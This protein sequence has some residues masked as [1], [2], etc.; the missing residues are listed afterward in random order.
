[1]TEE[2]Q[3]KKEKFSRLKSFLTCPLFSKKK[4]D[5]LREVHSESEKINDRIQT[6]ESSLKQFGKL[7]EESV[8]DLR[9]QQKAHSKKME[10]D[11]DRL[12]S[13]IESHI[14]KLCSALAGQTAQVQQFQK[15][16]LNKVDD[17][18]G[19]I[20]G[21]NGSIGGIRDY[22]SENNKTLQ[23]FQAGYDYQILKNFVK[24][25]T[26]TI[27]DLNQL[28]VKLSGDEKEDLMDA[29]DD[30][31]E[32]LERNG[33]EQ[34]EL[35][36]DAPYADQKKYAEAGEEKEKADDPQKSGLIASVERM[37]Y[38]YEFNDGQERVI[39]VARVKLYE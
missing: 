15:M 34:I 39:Q 17:A 32:L 6:V 12:N 35:D 23:R 8:K 21:V 38:R 18:A 7:L 22:L 10:R 36:F 33:V 2:A 16:A 25:V 4:A 30:L 19:T 37:G 5:E 13:D 9:K 26:R 11:S 24:P 28:L 29:R 3:A 31:L 1:M 14:Q 27:N 20:S